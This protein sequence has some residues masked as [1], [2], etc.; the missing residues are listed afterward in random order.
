M[1]VLTITVKGVEPKNYLKTET[2]LQVNDVYYVGENGK[3]IRRNPAKN[4]WK[5]SNRTLTGLALQVYEKEIDKLSKEERLNFIIRKNQSKSA[6]NFWIKGIYSS[7]EEYKKYRLEG[8]YFRY[9]DEDEQVKYV[10]SCG[11]IFSAIPFVGRCLRSFKDEK[12][13]FVLEYW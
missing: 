1:P 5:I 10:I 3:E 9:Y 2:G 11:D 13:K 8:D 7:L 6:Q 4:E 12:G